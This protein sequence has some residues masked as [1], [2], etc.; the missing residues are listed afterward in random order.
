MRSADDPVGA[1]FAALADSTRRDVVSCL[2][3]GPATPT[4]LASRLPV[5]RQAVAKHLTT[6]QS[7]GLVEVT[8]EGREAHYRL[9]PAPLTDAMSWMAQVGAE[10]DQRLDALRSILAEDG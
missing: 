9:T 6:L 2:S 3:A 4:Q 7:A 1:V 10:W 5:T 8:R